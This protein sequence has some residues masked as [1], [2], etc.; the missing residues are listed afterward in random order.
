MEVFNCIRTRRS[1]RGFF[2]Q[3]IDQKIIDKLVEAAIWAPSGKNGQ[4]WKLKIVTDTDVIN[5]LADQSIY[6][7]WMRTAPCII[8][9]FL[10]QGR[11]Y[12]YIKD[13][14]SC[15]AV[16]QNIAL[17]A[18]SLGIGSCWIGE[19]LSKAIRIKET[20]KIKDEPLELMGALALGYAERNTR[21]PGRRKTESFLL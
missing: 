1:V 3:P 2:D 13:V 17:C 6:G 9:V 4:P 5:H 14:Q 11:S 10:D 21:N 15:G 20:L 19:I 18:H 16:F 7:E 12:H 8:L